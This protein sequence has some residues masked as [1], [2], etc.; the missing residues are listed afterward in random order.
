MSTPSLTQFTR[1]PS[2]SFFLLSFPPSFPSPSIV[3]PGLVVVPP[4]VIAGQL[5]GT[6]CKIPQFLALDLD[7]H[8]SSCAAF[9]PIGRHNT[10]NSR[11]P[12][13]HQQPLQPCGQ[14]LATVTAAALSCDSIHHYTYPLHHFC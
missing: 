9:F 11:P 6:S 3:L 5:H 8:H 13:H 12:F 4:L 14:Q 2:L 10:V 7:P 1:L